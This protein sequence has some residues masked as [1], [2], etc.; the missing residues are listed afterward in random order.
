M[1]YSVE[2]GRQYAMFP[3]ISS[4]KLIRMTNNMKSFGNAIEAIII[5]II[6]LIKL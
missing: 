4:R 3:K 5:I 2:S 1:S 6:I